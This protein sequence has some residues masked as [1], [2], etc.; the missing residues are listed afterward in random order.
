MKVE[1]NQ[2]NEE[3]CRDFCGSC[4]SYPESAEWIF[5]ARRKS[6]KKI[7]KKGCLCTACQI[8]MDYDLS[9]DYFCT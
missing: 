1:D 4:P 3:I 9:N 5:C 7:V 8:F 6:R 2:K